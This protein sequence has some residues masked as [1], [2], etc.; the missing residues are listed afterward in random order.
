MEL[1]DLVRA[2][3]EGDLLAARQWVADAHRAHMQWEHIEPPHALSDRE[4]SIAAALV[5]LFAS[6]AGGK[7]PSW[8]TKAR[9]LEEPLI[10]DP[11]L[12]QM[13]RSFAHAKRYGPEPFRRRN[14]VV[15]PDFLE[16]A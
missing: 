14:L 3:L 9:A 13:P 1:P 4:M 7:P 11:G 15:L 12:E 8:T 2:I 16:I 5:E 6:R 10:L